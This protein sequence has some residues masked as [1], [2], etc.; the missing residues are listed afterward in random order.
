LGR[1]QLEWNQ[2]NQEAHLAEDSQSRLREPP[3]AVERSYPL[4]A[5]NSKSKKGIPFYIY[6]NYDKSFP[7]I[8]F[9]FGNSCSM[10]LPLTQCLGVI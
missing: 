7:A 4:S 9:F 2:K 5:N 1:Q 10:S 6:G 3:G 8:F